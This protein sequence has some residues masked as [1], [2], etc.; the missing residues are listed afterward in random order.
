MARIIIHGDLAL[1]RE[2]LKRLGIILTN[3]RHRKGGYVCYADK[4]LRQAL[5]AS[6]KEGGKA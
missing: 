6:T 4:Q 3:R 1:A 5:A 2:Q